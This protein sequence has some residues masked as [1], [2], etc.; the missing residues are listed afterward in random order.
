MS[1]IIRLSLFLV[2]VV[3]I[4]L[5]LIG[6]FSRYNKDIET[7]KILEALALAFG[8]AGVFTELHKS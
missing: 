8:L 1:V 5:V 3:S 2:G 6:I 7:A 4:V